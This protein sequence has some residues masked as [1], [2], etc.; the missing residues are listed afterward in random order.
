MMTDPEFESVAHNAKTF[1]FIEDPHSGKQQHAIRRLS[2]GL[3]DFLRH[4]W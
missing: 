2:I 4:L 1:E 3:Y